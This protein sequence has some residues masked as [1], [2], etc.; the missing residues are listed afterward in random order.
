[1]EPFLAVADLVSRTGLHDRA[2]SAL[3][4]APVLP[5][6]RSRGLRRRMAQLLAKRARRPLLVIRRAQYSPGCSPP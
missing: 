4:N 3:P 6:D 5:D 1:M 2:R